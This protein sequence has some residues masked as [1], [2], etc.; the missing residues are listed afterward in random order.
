VKK[1]A[2][3]VI[4]TIFNQKY[5]MA[6]LWLILPLFILTFLLWLMPPWKKVTTMNNLN[7][8]NPLKSGFFLFLFS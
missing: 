3:N 5:L 8:K 6:A 4:K 7:K 1:N 2:L